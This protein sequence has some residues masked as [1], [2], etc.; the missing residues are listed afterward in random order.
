MEIIDNRA[1]KFRVKNPDRI[2]SV[3]PKS[4]NLGEI[5]PGVSE[6]LVHFGLE[7]AQ[8]LRNLKLKGVRSPIAFTY[9]WPGIRKPFDHQRV[10]AE[11]MTLHKRCYI[12]NEQGSGKTSSALW[13]IDY[14]LKTR[15][16]KRALV[17]CPVSIMRSA[18]V[19]DAFQTIMHRDVA[20]AHG[21]KT[22][23]IAAIDSKAEI[24]VINYDGVDVIKHYL[25]D[26]FDLIVM[27]ECTFIKS[28][29]TRRWKAMNAISGPDTWMW[30]MTGTPSA[31]SPLDAFGLAKMCTPS[32]V[33]SYFGSWRD[34]VM[35]KI[36]MFKWVPAP[37]ATETV[38]AALQPAIRFTKEECL[39]LPEMLYHTRDVPM[40]K[41]QEK[42][43]A[44][45]KKQLTISAA[46]EQ[47]TAVHAAAALNKLLQISCGAA[48]SDTGDVIKFDADARLEEMLS[49]VQESSHK[50]VVFV[51]F[52]HAIH[53][54]KEYLEKH[55][56]PTECIYGDVSL[57]KRTDIF[58]RFQETDDPK[59]LVIQPQ[60]ASHGV[61]LT[62][63]STII[64]FGPTS[65]VETYLQ[66]N[67]RIHRAG[68]T[69]KT[70]VVRLCGSPAERKVYAALDNKE[71]EQSRLMQ[72]YEDVIK[73]E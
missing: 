59:V 63:A 16:I 66:G 31:Q 3:I 51:P 48:Y 68:Q 5:A 53:I 43:Y 38:N 9:D 44:L 67:A 71:L 7:E 57:G 65:S 58:R 13:A 12:L 18:W 26:K 39:D 15:T 10:T 37:R 35:V 41:Q 32:R 73:G 22:Q 33:P 11:F 62:A 46:G 40:S 42:Y 17:V 50:T 60:S 6:V 29:T 1:V 30:L 69:N 45:L 19:A 52:K 54:V 56:Y 49:V 70:L 28:S 61:T 36:G 64:W 47:I 23:R 25:K 72:L 20:V 24:V 4:K 55:G 21:T 2:T 27:D 14:L 8:V 34:K